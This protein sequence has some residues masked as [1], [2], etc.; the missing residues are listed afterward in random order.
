MKTVEYDIDMFIIEMWSKYVYG[1]SLSFI[2]LEI[3][4]FSF[5]PALHVWSL[6]TSVCHLII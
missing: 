4:V 3:I 6:D 1:G 2:T 5:S